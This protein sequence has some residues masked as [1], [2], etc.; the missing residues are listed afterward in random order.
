[1]RRYK[2]IGKEIFSD[3]LSWDFYGS[4]SQRHQT[5]LGPHTWRWRWRVAGGSKASKGLPCHV[6]FLTN[7]YG[8]ATAH[9]VV[10]QLRKA[11][12]IWW[13]DVRGGFLICFSMV[14]DVF[15][16]DRVSIWLMYGWYVKQ[17]MVKVMIVGWYWISYIHHRVVRHGD[18][19]HSKGNTWSPCLWSFRVLYWKLTWS[20]RSWCCHQKQQGKGCGSVV[21]SH[22]LL[23]KNRKWSTLI[24]II[25]TTIIRPLKPIT[26]INNYHY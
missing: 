20:E 25:I 18:F 22:F 1:M 17:H 6:A 7:K 19:L 23:V 8:E 10:S 21:V 2:K 15:V 16:C 14:R 4:A 11:I 9:G 3:L 24:V 26:V 12:F 5:Y 13:D